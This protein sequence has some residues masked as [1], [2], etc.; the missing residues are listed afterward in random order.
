M[1]SKQLLTLTYLHVIIGQMSLGVRVLYKGYNKMSLG[2]RVLHKC[3]NTTE[4]CKCY[5]DQLFL[6]FLQ[7]LSYFKN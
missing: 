7:K 5:K 6:S 1:V 4:T 2:V 3:Y